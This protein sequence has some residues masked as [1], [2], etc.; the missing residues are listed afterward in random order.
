[1]ADS[2]FD[3]ASSQE[4][5]KPMDAAQSVQSVVGD[6]G[7]FKFVSQLRTER[8]PRKE[9]T[10]SLL[11]VSVATKPVISDWME[12]SNS[13]RVLVFACSTLAQFPWG[14]VIF[15]L[16]LLLFPRQYAAA[17]YWLKN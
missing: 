14:Q 3:C 9:R 7:K 15:V 4:D 5:Q 13:V 17:E 16:G 8:E 12:F 6:T 2:T 11:V 10:M 1:M